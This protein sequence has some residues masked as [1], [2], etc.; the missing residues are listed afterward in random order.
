MRPMLS[1]W[2]RAS[3]AVARS[4]STAAF[5]MEAVSPVIAATRHSRKLRRAILRRVPR[6]GF[7]IL[8]WKQSHGSGSISGGIRRRR[9]SCG[10]RPTRLPPERFQLLKR[11]APVDCPQLSRSMLLAVSEERFQ[12]ELFHPLSDQE[13]EDG[14]EGELHPLLPYLFQ[15][16]EEVLEEPCTCSRCH[17]CR[18]RDFH[19]STRRRCRC[20]RFR[21]PRGCMTTTNRYMRSR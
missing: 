6:K 15:P 7:E 19:C 18:C 10:I 11:S 2:S 16:P 17:P 9:P 1:Y 21:R 5:A 4:P 13:L 3:D 12:L 8:Q 20:W 14:L